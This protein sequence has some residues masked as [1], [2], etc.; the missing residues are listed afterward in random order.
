MQFP[1]AKLLKIQETVKTVGK[2]NGSSVSK[3]SEF[4]ETLT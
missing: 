2:N 1:V 4:S 3:F